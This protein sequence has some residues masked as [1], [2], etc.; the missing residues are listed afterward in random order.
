MKQMIELHRTK[1]SIMDQQHDE[2]ADAV[3]KYF[4]KDDNSKESFT[5]FLENIG[6][7]AKI[8]FAAEEKLMIDWRYENFYSHKQ[9]HD[10]FL[11]KV[12]SYG[13]KDKD[14]LFVFIRDWLNNHLLM[15]D[16]KLGKFLSEQPTR[17]V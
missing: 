15:K 1:V 16:I 11:R 9:E 14:E 2:M 10:R 7:L 17:I 8:H 5:L 13:I 4:S 3:N 12:N 6:K